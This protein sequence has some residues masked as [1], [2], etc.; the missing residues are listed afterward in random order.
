MAAA[1]NM[2]RLTW[3]ACLVF[4]LGFSEFLLSVFDGMRKLRESVAVLLLHRVSY[5]PGYT[6]AH[7]AGILFERVSCR[8]ML[9]L[10]KHTT[11]GLICFLTAVHVES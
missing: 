9:C 3:E 11:Q 10:K 4:K 1:D 5:S 7:Q 6:Q 8:I 2:R